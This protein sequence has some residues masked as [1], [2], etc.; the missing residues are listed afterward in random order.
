MPDSVIPNYA[1]PDSC[2]DETSL[3]L[4]PLYPIPLYLIPLLHVIPNSVVPG[5]PKPFATGVVIAFHTRIRK[6][7]R[8]GAKVEGL[9]I[10][11]GDSSR[12]EAV[13]ASLALLA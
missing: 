6:T 13:R 3:C 4:I 9:N 11:F 7:F 8:I 1:I 10:W 2:F 12:K 5:S